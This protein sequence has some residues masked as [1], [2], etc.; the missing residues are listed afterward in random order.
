[1]IDSA[2]RNVVSAKEIPQFC[3]SYWKYKPE[4]NGP[5]VF[6]KEPERDSPQNDKSLKEMALS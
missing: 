3:C 6:K 2:D 1:M 5:Q 4:R